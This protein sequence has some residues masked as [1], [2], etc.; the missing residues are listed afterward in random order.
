MGN[1]GLIYRTKGDLDTALKYLKDA[2]DIHKKIGY[3]QG[4]AVA[5]GNIGQFYYAKGDLDTALKYLK[6]ALQILVEFKLTQWKEI[7]E[8]A[9]E[10]IEKE[11]KQK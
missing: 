6:D 9:I 4:E 10:I 11:K 7:I 5:L 2:L 1:I 3:K 8:N